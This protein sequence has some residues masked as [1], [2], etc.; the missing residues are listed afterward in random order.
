MKT[1]R[2][3]N[4]LNELKRY[5]GVYQ[6]MGRMFT[7]S[8][9]NE[10]SDMAKNRLSDAL[11][12]VIGSGTPRERGLMA[13]VDNGDGTQSHLLKWGYAYVNG[14]AAQVRPAVGA[15]LID[16]AGE[17]FEYQHQADFPAAPPLPVTEDYTYYL[18]VWERAVITLEDGELRDPGLHGA[19]T[20]TRTQTMAQVKWCPT[21]LDPE[22]NAVNPA[23]GDAELT[24]VLRA[25]STDPD[26][27][28]PC[29][30]E[31]AL[32]DKVGN[33]LFRVEVHQVEYDINGLPERV[34]LKWSSENGAEQYEI[35]SAPPGFESDNFTYEFYSG[36][37]VAETSTSEK[38]LGRHLATGFIATTGA[39]EAG[40]PDSPPG[41]YSLVRRWDG[42]CELVKA[43]VNWTLDSGSDVGTALSTAV[44]ADA[45]G[46]V[47]EGVS[48]ALYLDAMT[49]TLNLGDQQA[50][51]GDYWATEVRQDRDI[52]GDE[53]LTNVLPEGIRHHYMTLGSV[54]AGE[55]SAY[56]SEQCKR[57][58]F[59]PLTDIQ[60]KDVCYDNDACD[61]PAV[62]SV[63]EAI[64]YLCKARD[65]RWHNKHL[66]GWGIVCGLIAK[67]G[68]D[69][70][71]PGCQGE[72]NE[73][74]TGEAARRQI[75]I[76]KGYALT[77]LGEDVVLDEAIE[78]DLISYIE[79]LEKESGQPVLVNGEA[80][81]CLRIDLGANGQPVVSVEAYDPLKHKKSMLDGTLL[82]DF[83]ENCI[84]GLI[85]SIVAEFSFLDTDEVEKI[86]GGSTGLV[87]IE[88]RKFTSAINLLVQLVNS[89]NGSYVFLSQREHLILRDLYHQLRC[90]LQSATFCGMFQDEEFP[91]YPFPDRG[92]TTI[93]GKNNH[94]RIK[95]HPN[96]KHLYTYGGTDNTINV[97]ELANGQL[98]N[99]LE[100]PSA[101][102]AEVSAITFSSDGALLFATANVRGTDSVFGVA[103][104]ADDYAW[105][106]M[107]IL[108]NINIT[109][110]QVA[111]S[112]DGLIYA[113]GHG[114][115]LFYLRPSIMMDENKPRPLP[116]H[117]FNAVG[118]MV[119]DEKNGVA[120]CTSQSDDLTKSAR[121]DEII[122]CV[123]ALPTSGDSLSNSIPLR[124]ITGEPLSGTDGLA[125][126]AADGPG[127]MVNGRL[128]VI[129]DDPEQQEHKLLLTYGGGRENASGIP[130][131][132]YGGERESANVIPGTITPVENTQISLAFHH[133]SDH[134][135]LAMEDGY[136]L[137]LMTA[138]GDA[139]SY[140]RTPVQI[141]PTD[142]IVDT[143]NGQVYTLNF[144]S[145]T[146][147]V[148]PATELMVDSEFLLT[149]AAY[150][151]DVLL[152]FYELFGN[153]LQYI[154]DCFCDHLLVKCPECDG[155]EILYLA[156][157][158]IREN[159]VY[160]VCNFD[161]RK[162]VKSF[163]VMDYWMSL[164]P[165]MPLIKTA[166]SKFCCW[167]MP[168]FFGSRRDSLIQQP[169]AGGAY[170]QASQNNVTAARGRNTVQTYGRTDFRA[171][172]RDQTTGFRFFG[173]LA[174]DRVTQVVAPEVRS[175]RG[176]KKQAL[177]KSSVNDA[178]KELQDNQVEVVGIKAYD[179]TQEATYLAD[180]NSTP[181][182]LVA[183][184]KVTLIQ[185]G[186]KVVFYSVE[187]PA[188]ATS[189]EISD[190][191]KA[192][193]V[194]LEKRKANLADFR[195]VDAALLD[196]E[197][198]RERVVELASVSGDLK[199][200]QDEK[201]TV[202]TELVA[203][204]TQLDQVSSARLAEEQKLVEMNSLRSSIAG[205]LVDMNNSLLAV[206]AMQ[207][208][209]K[210]EVAR[211]RP[212]KEIA[213]VNETI[214]GNLREAGVRTIDELATATPA[215]LSQAAAI[216]RGTA[217]TLINAAKK[218]LI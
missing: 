137:Q 212:V 71:P 13:I 127:D 148:I 72:E 45:H 9:W 183:G 104:I 197:A 69:T 8:D 108:C 15:T 117:S 205:D 54:V 209:I 138:D 74:D 173:R 155:D 142:V 93:F 1:Q 192:E 156:N 112:D 82:M 50:L 90:V 20:C 34:V 39:L 213:G 214:D 109:E 175:D 60:A 207:E 203:L 206:K 95:Q 80:S 217:T 189:V 143:T 56:E 67:C 196:T 64:D 121:Y 131:L 55:F 164:V 149:L 37:S 160:K 128:Y 77:C 86:E 105:E 188:V 158:D 96:G 73:G 49:V 190:E 113:I 4:S 144:I 171:L 218:R 210:L 159:R 99:V 193:M 63:Q 200:L 107:A 126:R 114:M 3:R 154:K 187:K 76:T 81:V 42:Y 201:S 91:E 157:V 135:I 194:Q 145:N 27:C 51:S 31:I 198:R 215:K 2:S 102:G 152:V 130:V 211:S 53:L 70:Y 122:A 184:S 163:P 174:G 26:P 191:T 97:F 124:G 6:Q 216:P 43:G 10:L 103:R 85:E 36:P 172:W 52:A 66:H 65:L 30:D 118:H 22:D 41:G 75:L 179:A 167:V 98:I 5:S 141:Q 133:E 32:Q 84:L 92:M 21:T 182:R 146:I 139:S 62:D 185:D 46:Y 101:A 12:D 177:M 120:Y 129:A 195:D 38:Q 87:S 24:L 28:D 165:V 88:R 29:A 169:T 33:Y 111:A 40:Y 100:M 68:S 151:T 125:I 136:R 147:S 44:A 178:V 57:F 14:I 7:D 204:K 202:E 199:V 48:V 132:S 17:L 16:P 115:G 116:V 83:F 106:Q 140:Y 168:D 35:D 170:K 79:N 110:M 176:V 208:E 166:V 150:R 25:G 78:L 180:Y 186:G 11:A 119:I 19:D 134:L 58:D 162:Y 23:I 94:T 153:L 47:V 89:E 59:P 18:D 123:L 161:K 181:P 61:M